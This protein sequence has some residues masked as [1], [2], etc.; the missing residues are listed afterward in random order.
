MNSVKQVNDNER[1][2]RSNGLSNTLNFTF[3]AI[4]RGQ[5]R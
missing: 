3:N 4:T 5:H 1:K 2:I